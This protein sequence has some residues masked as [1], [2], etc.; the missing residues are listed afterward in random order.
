[1]K[2]NQILN[3]VFVYGKDNVHAGYP[4]LLAY[5]QH[6]WILHKDDENLEQY[7]SD[8]SEIFHEDFESIDDIRDKF[9]DRP[10]E[11]VFGDID[12]GYL[13]MYSGDI[14]HGKQSPTLQ[15]ALKAAGLYGISIDYYDD[16]AGETS[17]R[18]DREDF[19]KPISHEWFYHGTSLKAL[20]SIKNTGIRPTGK[21]NFKYI[22]HEDKV[23]IS[24]NKE[25]ALFY[26][27]NT[28]A[29]DGSFPVILK[30]KV[31]DPD[32]LVLDY[33]VAI[34]IY[35]KE[36]PE[37]IKLGYS[38]IHDYATNE[39]KAIAHL[40]A[41]EKELMNVRKNPNWL[42]TRLGVFGYIGRI[43][44]TFIDSVLIDEEAFRG[45]VLM[46]EFGGEPPETFESLD[47]WDEYSVNDLFKLYDEI[48]DEV[49]SEFEEDE[50]DSE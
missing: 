9:M 2:L 31:P 6:V 25:K 43:P 44:A 38:D 20:E 14:R 29:K 11:V 35:G 33:D 16:I 23:F 19:I 34:D 37:T 28:T 32:K 15:K 40:K 47:R 36:H 26:S 4:S 8:I 30:L 3:E 5:R 1:M 49:Q 27:H 12:D 41:V 45:Y 10:G 50:E 21:T 18:E 39:Y 22:N 7:L 48:I 46:Q 13:R 42:N 24:L 17:F